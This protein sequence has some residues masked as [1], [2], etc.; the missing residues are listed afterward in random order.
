MVRHR[1]NTRKENDLSSTRKEFG[2]RYDV[3]T[4]GSDN[5]VLICACLE[6]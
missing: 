6:I 1:V 3:S 4:S 2:K 5:L